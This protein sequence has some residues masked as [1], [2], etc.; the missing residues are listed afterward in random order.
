M[1][2][3]GQKGKCKDD[4]KGYSLDCF[5]QVKR[6]KNVLIPRVISLREITEPLRQ[7]NM[8]INDLSENV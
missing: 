4:L 3:Q 1:K 2:M 6:S 5:E 7:I 8:E